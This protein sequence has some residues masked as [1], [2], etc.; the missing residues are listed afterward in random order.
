MPTL[1]DIIISDHA[2]FLDFLRTL[3]VI[4]P[5]RRASA[6][7]ALAHEFVTNF[8][9]FEEEKLMVEEEL[10]PRSEESKSKSTTM[11]RSVKQVAK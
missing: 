1:D 3:L 6:S 11:P 2:P 9:L 8:D 4:D 5:E 7:E 10:R